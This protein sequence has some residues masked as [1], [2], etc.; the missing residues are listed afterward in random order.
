MRKLLIVVIV[1]AG[2][3]VVADRV[4]VVV[5]DRQIASRVQSAYNLSS[6]PS[7]SVHGIPVPHPGCVG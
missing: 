3:L 5:A 4:A 6:K 2:L 7:V 1:L